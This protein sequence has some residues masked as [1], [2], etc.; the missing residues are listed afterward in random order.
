M[1]L[2]MIH[3]I[4]GME[5]TETCT[6]HGNRALKVSYSRAIKPVGSF[7]DSRRNSFCPRSRQKWNQGYC[8]QPGSICS[9]V[10][11]RFKIVD[12]AVRIVSDLVNEIEGQL[13]NNSRL[14]DEEEEEDRGE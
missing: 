6:K 12:T 3:I 14:A 11:S 5:A 8:C 13:N 10:R 7:V 4:N 9:Y 1:S 2:K